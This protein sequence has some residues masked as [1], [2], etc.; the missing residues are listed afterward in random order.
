M[1]TDSTTFDSAFPFRATLEPP[2]PLAYFKHRWTLFSIQVY[3][4]AEAD[5]FRAS[6]DWFEISR[7]SYDALPALEVVR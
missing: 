2:P 5:A 6:T 7:A 1:L 4:E 3:S